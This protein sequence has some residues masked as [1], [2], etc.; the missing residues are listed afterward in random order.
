VPDAGKSF[1]WIEGRWIVPNPYAST[2]DGNVDYTSQ[3]IGIDGDGSGDVFQAG[4][5][6]DAQDVGGNVQRNIY[7]WWEWFPNFE[8]G[9]TNFPVAAG[10][11]MYC[12]LCVN[13]ATTGSIYLRNVSNGVATSFTVTAPEGT[14]LVGNSAEWIVERPTLI[15]GNSSFLP[16][17]A[18]YSLVYF[19]ECYA[20]YATGAPGSTQSETEIDFGSATFLTM[21]G[22]N[23]VSL[24]VPSEDNANSMEVNWEGAN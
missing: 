3:W 10:D 4:T 6:A 17:L 14:N 23:G 12:L 7:A 8:V 21:T 19:D 13:S 9:I 2:S 5:E 11:T 15:S 22:N 16:A 24:S 20:Y 1:K 18:N